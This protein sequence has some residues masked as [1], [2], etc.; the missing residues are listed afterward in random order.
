M[1]QTSG[2]TNCVL[3][4]VSRALKTAL[5]PPIYRIQV[6]LTIVPASQLYRGVRRK[7]QIGSYLLAAAL[8]WAGANA[9][10]MP[11]A[12]QDV[13]EAGVPAFVVMG[14][15]ALGLSTAPTD[16]HVLSDGRVLVVSQHEI[17]FGDGVRWETF[18]GL[19]DQ[20]NLLTQV[21]VECGRRNLRRHGERHC[22]A[23]ST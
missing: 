4:D 10:A 20:A 17:A 15:E 19:P 8:G 5:I 23:G 18:R 14:P 1:P 7:I 2:S 22:K 12:A 13:L 11:A 6:F 16:L 3:E 21:A 9:H